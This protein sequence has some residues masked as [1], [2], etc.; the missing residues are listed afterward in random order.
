MVWIDYSVSSM[1]GGFGVATLGG[2][3]QGGSSGKKNS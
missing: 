2:R 3:D 1:K